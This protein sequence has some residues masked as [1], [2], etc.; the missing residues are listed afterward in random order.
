MHPRIVASAA[1]V[2]A[3]LLSIGPGV[4]HPGGHG[5]GYDGYPQDPNAPPPTPTPSVVP[6]TFVGLVAA[7]RQ[8]ADRA[9]V[10]V[11]AA[12]I[13]DLHRHARVLRELAAA[14]PDRASSL[15][16][17]AQTTAQSTATHLTAEVDATTS[18]ARAGDTGAAWSALT[19]VVADIDVLARLAR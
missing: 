4:A 12:R 10:A 6:A 17:A 16:P 3:A 2:I 9:A 15:P 11:E 19:R 5:G 8:R 13:V 18:A 7:L 14:V 1:L